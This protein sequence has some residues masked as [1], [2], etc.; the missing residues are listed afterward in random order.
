M[1]DGNVKVKAVIF[2]LLLSMILL[3][4]CGSEPAVDE[5]MQ[6]QQESDTVQS[7]DLQADVLQPGAVQDEELDS[8]TKEELV[9]Q[10]LEDKNMDTSILKYSK[11]TQC[12]FTLPEG[13]EEAEDLPGLYLNE[14]YPTDAS[15]I[16]Y[17]ELEKDT[18]LQLM[19]ENTFKD[20]MESELRNSYGSEVNI[21]IETFEKIEIDGFA[22]FRIL[23]D[24]ISGGIKFTQLQYIINAEKTY[25]ITYS[26]TDEYDRMEEFEASAGTIQIN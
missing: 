2:S 26:Q 10:L 17:V 6:T 8:E 20:N 14:H 18:A 7:E 13:F 25:V 16:Y 12:V 23:Y 1:S 9:A 21:N 22:S 3:N 11:K 19:S 5:T 4:G 24:Y 15:T